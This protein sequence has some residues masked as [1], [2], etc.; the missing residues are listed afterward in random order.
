MGEGKPGG[1]G[2]AVVFAH[3]ARV[4][5]REALECVSQD[6]GIAKEETGGGGAED[7]SVRC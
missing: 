2:S 4:D 1:R 3:R 6:T 7:T 5:K